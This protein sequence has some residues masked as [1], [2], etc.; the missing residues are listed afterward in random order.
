LENKIKW[1]WYE[2]LT[3]DN[4]ATTHKTSIITFSAVDAIIALENIGKRGKVAIH[5]RSCKSN[6]ENSKKMDIA[7]RICI[8]IQG[9]K[10]VCERVNYILAN[11]ISDISRLVQGAKHIEMAIVQQFH[12]DM[13]AI[14]KY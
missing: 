5:L 13:S 1:K 7:L 12:I 14:N 8:A 4:M 6:C 3:S 11:W 10:C 9:C 2:N